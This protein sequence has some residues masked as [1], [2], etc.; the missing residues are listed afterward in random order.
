VSEVEGGMITCACGRRR[1]VWESDG[2][3]RGVRA[4]GDVHGERESAHGRP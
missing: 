3:R 4:N 1:G 2:G